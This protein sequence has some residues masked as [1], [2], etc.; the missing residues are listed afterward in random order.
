MRRAL[1]WLIH[2]TITAALWAVLHLHLGLHW[3]AA[4]AACVL[5]ALIDD[6]AVAGLARSVGRR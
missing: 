1:Y 3:V 6:T 4:A 2:I 5:V